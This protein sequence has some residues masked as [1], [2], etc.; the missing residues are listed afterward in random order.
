VRVILHYNIFIILYLVLIEIEILMYLEFIWIRTPFMLRRMGYQSLNQNLL[1][2]LLIIPAFW[3][4]L[5]TIVYF[6]LGFQFNLVLLEL[7][8]LLDVSN[9]DVA[10]LPLML[11]MLLWLILEELVGVLISKG[12]IATIL[13]LLYLPEMRFQTLGFI[14]C[15]FPTLVIVWKLKHYFVQHFWRISQS[16]TSFLSKRSKINHLIRHPTDPWSRTGWRLSVLV[17]LLLIEFF[18]VT[19]F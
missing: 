1:I 9:H 13:I 8:L 3:F 12:D 17:T 11:W 15:P 7:H 16:L 2:F 10:M 6:I 19:S 4:S 5:Y 14:P 18:K